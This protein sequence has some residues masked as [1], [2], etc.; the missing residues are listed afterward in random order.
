MPNLLIYS[1]ANLFITVS[2]LWEGD[3]ALSLRRPVRFG[4]SH[5]PSASNQCELGSTSHHSCSHKLPRIQT[6]PIRCHLLTSGWI[7]RWKWCTRA[8]CNIKLTVLNSDTRPH[9]MCIIWATNKWDHFAD[10]NTQSCGLRPLRRELRSRFLTA[11][12]QRRSSAG[13]QCRAARTCWPPMWPPSRP[14]AEALCAGGRTRP[15]RLCACD[16]WPAARRA[17]GRADVA[18]RSGLA[19]EREA[20]GCGTRP[21]PRTECARGRAARSSRRPTREAVRRAAGG[22][23]ASRRTPPVPLPMAALW[24]KWI[25]TPRIHSPI[26]W[27]QGVPAR[28]LISHWLWVLLGAE[29]FVADKLVW[30]SCLKGPIGMYCCFPTHRV[31]RHLHNRVIYKIIIVCT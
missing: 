5:V 1:I 30:F 6:P 7:I 9:L 2:C 13:F 17:R 23:C 8:E 24:K 26:Y 25:L 12:S 19:S 29:E 21:M 15:A 3:C 18:R 22:P 31:S 27:P 20:R 10:L 4:R 28:R 14:Q 11:L 16:G